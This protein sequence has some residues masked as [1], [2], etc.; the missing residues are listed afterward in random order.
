MKRPNYFILAF[1]FFSAGISCGAVLLQSSDRDHPTRLK[2][3]ELTGDVEATGKEYFYSF[4]ARPGELTI[5]AD[6]KANGSGAT[7]TYE[8]LDQSA[9]KALLCCEYVQGDGA[10]SGRQSDKLRFAKRQIVILH[11]TQPNSGGGTFR[12]RFSGAGAPYDEKDIP[13]G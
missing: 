7:V 3:N 1:L 6:V 2:A 11:Y 4:V 10:G 8:L 13:Q 5:T 12:F 9:S